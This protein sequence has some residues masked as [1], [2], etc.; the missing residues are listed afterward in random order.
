MGAVGAAIVIVA[1]AAA[2]GLSKRS[3]PGA[4]AGPAASPKASPAS[5]AQGSR[6]AAA[7]NA[8]LSSSASARKSLLVPIRQVSFCRHLPRAT[9]QIQ[10]VVNERSA[11]YSHVLALPTA[12][13]ANGATV[14]AD[15]VAALRHSL[16]ADRDY[17][18]WARQQLSLG[19]RPVAHSSAYQAALNADGQADAAKAAFVRVWNPVAARYGVQPKT[20]GDI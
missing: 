5:F 18:I 4:T 6:Q 1:V 17:L 14:K 11:E 9:G 13:M 8:L 19:C 15:L 7:L 12:A 16:D 3:A 20:T 2:A 10:S